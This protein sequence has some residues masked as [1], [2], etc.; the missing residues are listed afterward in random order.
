MSGG[1]GGGNPDGRIDPPGSPLGYTTIP[2]VPNGQTDFV[3][4]VE[5]MMT[6]KEEAERGR[7]L[8]AREDGTAGR[9]GGGRH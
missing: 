5:E 9:R 7:Q 1:L 2:G 6:A 3:D 8:Q 4:L